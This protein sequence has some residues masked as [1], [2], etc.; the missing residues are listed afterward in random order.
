M[1]AVS[2]GPSPR[3]GNEYIQNRLLSGGGGATMLFRAYRA[4]LDAPVA[5]QKAQNFF[6]GH[7]RKCMACTLK[8]TVCSVSIAALRFILHEN[9]GGC[10][11][12]CCVR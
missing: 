1:Q 7:N 3:G 12:E 2:R 11:A 6:Q 8:G 10:K 5:I 4:G 9:M